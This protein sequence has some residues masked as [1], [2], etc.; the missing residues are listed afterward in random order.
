MSLVR[1]FLPISVLCYMQFCFAF[2]CCFS[3]CFFGHGHQLLR[4]A[5]WSAV[6]AR[7]TLGTLC[8]SGQ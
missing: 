1:F 8:P 2:L 5:G 7:L 4:V 3:M 6:L